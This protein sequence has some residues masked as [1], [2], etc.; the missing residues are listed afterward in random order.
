MS[1]ADGRPDK[2]DAEIYAGTKNG[3]RAKQRIYALVHQ[4][5][6]EIERRRTKG[7]GGDV[8]SKLADEIEKN[9]LAALHSLQGLL[10]KD[11]ATAGKTPTLNLSALFV[12]AAR[13]VGMM[14][15]N[16]SPGASAH[17]ATTPMASLLELTAQPVSDTAANDASASSVFDTEW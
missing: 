13:E 12:Q 6:D 1:A 9:P 2:L 5:L 3:V 16:Q 15:R 14:G 10:P 7:R 11:E 17:D 8:V 4:A